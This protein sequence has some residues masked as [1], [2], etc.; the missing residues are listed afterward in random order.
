MKS[1]GIGHLSLVI[2]AVCVGLGGLGAII[3]AVSNGPGPAPAITPAAQAQAVADHLQGKIGF[4]GTF[5]D[6]CGEPDHFRIAPNG[7]LMWVY[8]EQKV[9]VSFI[10]QKKTDKYWHLM[11]NPYDPAG[12][13]EWGEIKVIEPNVALA[14]IGCRIPANFQEV[15]RLEKSLHDDFV[16]NAAFDAVRSL[17]KGSGGGAGFRVTSAQFM[18]DGAVC[19]R[20]SGRDANAARAVV[21][22]GELLRGTDAQFNQ[23]WHRE[24]EGRS[25]RDEAADLMKTLEIWDH[26]T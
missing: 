6:F 5:K 14:R 21:A 3:H 25:G 11:Y 10:K 16:Y 18:E 22:G 19:Y 12:Y 20:Y 24:C 7:A 26:T 4:P 15:L 8:E 1:G 2:I 17:R 9:V 23:A 13:A